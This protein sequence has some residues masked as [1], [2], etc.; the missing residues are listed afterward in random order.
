MWVSTMSKTCHDVHVHAHEMSAVMVLTHA[1][2]EISL[3]R[4][5]FELLL[6][7]LL[8]LLAI[9]SSLGGERFNNIGAHSNGHGSG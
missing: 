1:A 5:H 6:C 8:R 7:L 4:I 3:L 9:S 2:R